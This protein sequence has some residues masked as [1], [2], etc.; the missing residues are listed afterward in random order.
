MKK[1]IKLVSAA[2]LALIMVIALCGCG[3]S[4]LEKA[5]EELSKIED[6]SFLD[7]SY[8]SERDTLVLSMDLNSDV[9]KT[10]DILDSC[11]EGKDIGTIV[12]TTT[13]NMGDEL[14]SK[15]DK[16]IG[17]LPCSSIECLG[18]DYYVLCG[19]SSK[20]H[21]WTKMLDKADAIYIESSDVS[22]YYEGK[23]LERIGKIKNVKI[24]Y[25]W[26]M[27]F[28]NLKMLKEVET[29]SLVPP[30]YKYHVEG[31]FEDSDTGDTGTGEV[32][33]SPNDITENT[34]EEAPQTVVFSYSSPSYNV[35]E[36]AS[37]KNLKTLLIYPDT[38]YELDP[39]G[40]LFIKTL[41]Y[42]NDNIQVNKP[43]EAYS[44][45]SEIPV[46]EIETPNVTE[47]QAV[48]ILEGLL[49]KDLNEVYNECAKYDKVDGDAVLT[50]KVL[51]YEATP[52]T[53][54]WSTKREYNSNGNIRLSDAKKN[55][56]KIP[57][58]LG[59]YQTFVYI[60]PTYTRTG[61]YTSGTIAYSETLHVQVFNMSEKK[62]YAAETVGSAA[63]PQSFSYYEG[64]MPDKKSGDVDRG[65]AFEY[66]KKLSTES[67][68]S[69]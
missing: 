18:L 39:S 11:I 31:S 34:D 32:P 38:G 27:D 45:G 59:D 44:G 49:K 47:E 35:E 12:F 55:G 40:E 69:Q 21:E 20:V 24:G 22:A 29:I 53:G 23:D 6:D 65:K 66:L 5:Y 2:I 13:G 14:E 19:D 25:Q 26:G 1:H 10:M 3:K 54:E 46:K 33:W 37:L 28:G 4:A 52:P 50:G 58:G 42:V 56:I 43:G 60:Y 62:T 48:S 15:L 63:A 7:M 9:D 64:S 57:E 51:V 17:Q 67:G 68:A 30:Y 41:Q 16:R 61:S 8:D 36:F